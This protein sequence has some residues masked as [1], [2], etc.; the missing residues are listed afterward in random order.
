MREEDTVFQPV[1][2]SVVRFA[3]FHDNPLVENKDIAVPNH[4]ACYDLIPLGRYGFLAI[5]SAL[6]RDLFGFAGHDE[7]A[8]EPEYWIPVFQDEFTLFRIWLR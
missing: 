5:R 3:L 1:T 2:D 6:E 8:S 4:P 7:D